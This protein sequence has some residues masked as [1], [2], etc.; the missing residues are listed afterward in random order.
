MH[1]NGSNT[2][3]MNRNNLLGLYLGYTIFNH[4]QGRVMLSLIA[5]FFGGEGGVSYYTLTMLCI[6]Y[7]PLL[8]TKQEGGYP[9]CQPTQWDLNKNLQSQSYSYIIEIL[10]TTKGGVVLVKT[11]NSTFNLKQFLH[12]NNLAFHFSTKQLCQQWAL[13]MGI[14]MPEYQTILSRQ[15]ISK[16]VKQT[17]GLCVYLF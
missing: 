9:Y 13:K 14:R 1:S 5:C 11:V 3:G 4:L 6:I 10:C 17:V 16:L 12:W 2:S 7:K 15:Y 8:G